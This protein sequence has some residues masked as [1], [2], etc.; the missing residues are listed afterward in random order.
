MEDTF[1]HVPPAKID[2]LAA[3]YQPVRAKDNKIELYRAPEFREP[4]KYFG[5]TAGLYSTA[6]DYFRFHQMMLNGGSLGD[7]RILGTKTVDLIISN[8]I[9]PELSAY[10]G[11]GFGLGY[12]ILTDAGKAVEPLRPGS[13]GWGGAWGTYF[14]VD[15]AEKMQAIVMAQ[16]TRH[17]HLEFRY[18]LSVLA[19]QAVTESYRH[20]P[21]IVM[22]YEKKW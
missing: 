10:D 1:Y 13:F 14:W 5:G 6:A 20:K 8:H 12:S 2:R 19:T 22:G 15:P 3:V 7:A 9:E 4:T 11:Y 17:R 18:M 21:P 16:I